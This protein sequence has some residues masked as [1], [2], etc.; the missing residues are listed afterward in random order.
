M[1]PTQPR[2]RPK[3]PSQAALLQRV[4]EEIERITAKEAAKKPEWATEEKW[5]ELQARLAGGK[6]LRD[7]V[8]A[9][10]LVP[11]PERLWIASEQ[12]ARVPVR[13]EELPE[14]LQIAIR[15]IEEAR[16]EAEFQEYAAGQWEAE[17]ERRRVAE[18]TPERFILAMRQAEEAKTRR[19]PRAPYPRVSQ[20]QYIRGAQRRGEPLPTRLFRFRKGVPWPAEKGARGVPMASVSEGEAQRE[21]RGEWPWSGYG[22]EMLEKVPWHVLGEGIGGGWFRGPAMPYSYGNVALGGVGELVG[23]EYGHAA[24]EPWLYRDP[25]TGQQFWRD[26]RDW[27]M[28]KPQEEW[29]GDDYFIYRWLLEAGVTELYAGLSQRPQMLPPEL[30]HWFPHYDLTKRRAMGVRQPL[31][32][33]GPAFTEYPSKFPPAPPSPADRVYRR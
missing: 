22:R 10:G 3:R 31:G 32:Y 27:I 9:Q 12:A 29:T 1:H 11:M 24:A 15:Q 26:V 16:R 4:A 17:Q 25:A 21:I 13:E 7:E 23:H 5:G 19:A 20:E 30:E 2:Q 6:A 18:S 28:S 8:K 14:R 33:R